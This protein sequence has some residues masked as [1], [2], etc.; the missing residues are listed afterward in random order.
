[1]VPFLAASSAFSLFPPYKSWKCRS[2]KKKMEGNGSDPKFR[3]GTTSGGDV[4]Q[5]PSALGGTVAEVERNTCGFPQEL[6]K[7]DVNT[8][9]A[10]EPRR[11]PCRSQHRVLSW[12]AVASLCHACALLLSD[13]FPSWLVVCGA[14]SKNFLVCRLQQTPPPQP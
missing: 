3:G 12:E 1:M 10:H 4:R 5:P 2:F 11:G 9:V 8:A 6:A 14:P 7:T 13:L